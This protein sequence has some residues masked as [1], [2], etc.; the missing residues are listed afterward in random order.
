MV[1]D[2]GVVQLNGEL[3]AVGVIVNVLGAQA[4]LSLFVTVIEYVSP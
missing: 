3:H 4:V 1:N 2:N